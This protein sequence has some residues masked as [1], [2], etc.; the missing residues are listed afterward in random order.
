MPQYFFHVHIVDGDI[1][2][3]DI[4]ADFL[5]MEDA[6]KEAEQYAAESMSE[7]IMKGK[8]MQQ[9]IEIMDGEGTVIAHIECKSSIEIRRQ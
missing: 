7:A 5:S 4:G 8:S 2:K 6:I 3:D 1:E 9:V